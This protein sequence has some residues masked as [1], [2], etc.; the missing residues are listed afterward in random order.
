MKAYTT[1]RLDADGKA[2]NAASKALM[3]YVK[4]VRDD[5]DD[6][7]LTVHSLRHTYKDMLREA[8]VPEE[9]QNFLMGHTSG[10]QGSRYGAGPPLRLKAEYVEKL[11]LSFLEATSSVS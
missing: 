11:D 7:R 10:G 2:Q 8:E 4:V 6:P 1:Y 3:R 5:S 9:I